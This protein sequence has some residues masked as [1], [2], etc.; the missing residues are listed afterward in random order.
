MDVNKHSSRLLL[1]LLS[2]SV[3]WAWPARAEKPAEKKADASGVTVALWNGGSAGAKKATHE[4]PHACAKNESKTCNGRDDDCNGKIDEGCGMKSGALQLLGSWDTHTGLDLVVRYTA[5]GKSAAMGQMGGGFAD[6]KPELVIGDAGKL[7]KQIDG[8]GTCACKDF[9]WV[10]KQGYKCDNC[11]TVDKM[12]RAAD[13]E[14][15]E[16]V[17]FEG[18]TLPSGTYEVYFENARSCPDSAK[19]AMTLAVT[20]NGKYIGTYKSTEIGNQSS[21]YPI[22]TLTVP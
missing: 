6:S 19:S 8:Q 4:V 21:K 13:K 9:T 7:I 20:A 18:T 11:K 16:N 12:C 2:L 22:L 15:F 17:V 5:P 1:G 3:F 10:N 14:Y